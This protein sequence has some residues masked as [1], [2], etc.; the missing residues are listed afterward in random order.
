MPRYIKDDTL[1]RLVAELAR[2]RG[3]T[4]HDAV[5]IAV[6]AELDRTADAVPL[7]DLFAALRGEH[8]LPPRTGQ[9]ANKA[10]LDELSGGL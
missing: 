8:K 3:V 5:K 10:F 7:R 1:A 4:R 6:T 9:P 2:R